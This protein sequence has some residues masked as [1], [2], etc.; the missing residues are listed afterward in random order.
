MTKPYHI[1]NQ[2]ENIEPHGNLEQLDQT[3][4]TIADQAIKYKN[5]EN[6]EN[7]FHLNFAR[8]SLSGNLGYKGKFYIAKR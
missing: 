3:R 6:L 8:L 7:S 2:A 5:D 4:T 1:A